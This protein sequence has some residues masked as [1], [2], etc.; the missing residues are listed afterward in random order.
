MAT[1]EILCRKLDDL[2]NLAY[3]NMEDPHYIRILNFI[4]DCV[5]IKAYIITYGKNLDF[6]EATIDRLYSLV[7][8]DLK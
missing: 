2:I 4:E 5:A 7:G 3:K 1:E 6:Y 8:S